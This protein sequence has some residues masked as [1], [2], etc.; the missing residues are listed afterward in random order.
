VRCLTQESIPNDS[1]SLIAKE[2]DE[3]DKSGMSDFILANITVAG[4]CRT[5]TGFP[6]C[7][8]RI[9]AAGALLSLWNLFV[10][11]FDIRYQR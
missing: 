1:A 2:Y 4:Q 11:N 6:H 7:A 5:L 10:E 9:R 8:P 3:P